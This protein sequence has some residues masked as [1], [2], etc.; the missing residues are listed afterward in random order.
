M[1]RA[2]RSK[3]MANAKIPYFQV[4]EKGICKLCKLSTKEFFCIMFCSY[5]RERRAQHCSYCLS[6]LYKTS[7]KRSIY[8][9][10][11]QLTPIHTE[12]VSLSS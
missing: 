3:K 1:V 10:E 12:L 5:E 7:R 8:I 2:S 11:L 6:M 4:L 9:Q